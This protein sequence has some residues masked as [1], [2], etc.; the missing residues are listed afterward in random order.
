MTWILVHLSLDIRMRSKQVSAMY[1][2]W[3]YTWLCSPLVCKEKYGEL[4][5]FSMVTENNEND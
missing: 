5:A 3:F 2:S 1:I 4:E